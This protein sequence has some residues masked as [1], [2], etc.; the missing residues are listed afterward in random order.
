MKVSDILAAAK[1]LLA[2]NGGS[3]PYLGDALDVLCLNDTI[4]EEERQATAD[5]ATQHLS[6]L[7]PHTMEA[8]H[9]ALIWEVQGDSVA[10][11]PISE[12]AWG[13]EYVQ[14]RNDWL[15]SLIER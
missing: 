5:A 1:L 11:F 8:W 12:R 6:T 2:A 9:R 14:F 7:N 15:D 3:V 4:T 13:A 10:V